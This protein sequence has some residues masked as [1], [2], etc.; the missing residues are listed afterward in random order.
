MESAPLKKRRIG[1]TNLYVTELG[2][3]GASIGNLFNPISNEEAYEV[4]STS[5]ELGI[6]YFDTAPEYGHGLSERRLGEALRN[7]PANE[8]ILSTKVGELLY[9]RH[10]QLP[11]PNKFIDKLP[12]HLKHDYS[13]DGVMRAFEDSL[14]RLGLTK[15]NI[16]F[17]H[18][19]DPIIHEENK[20]LLH[21]KTFIES[22][23][24]ALE[25]LRSAGIVDAIGLGVKKWEVC[26]EVMRY[27]NYDCFMLQGNYTLLEQSGAN[28]LDAC[29]KKQVSILLAGP[30]ASGILATG[31]VKGAYFHH[32]IA[33]DEILEQ[34]SAI[35]KI[36]DAFNIPMQAAAI[37]FPLK[38]PAVASVVVG[39]SS[40]KFM[41]QNKDFF[42]VPI[43][44]KLWEELQLAGI[45]KND[46]HR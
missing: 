23:Y 2:L 25:E 33:S 5:W 19:L 11:S 1:K 40:A 31:P 35:Q 30:Y 8:F 45:I 29:L 9:A 39:A 3:G 43:P 42:N 18:D 41:Q 36:C 12:F 32:Q 10:N 15:I 7:T 13:Y 14:Q 38:H 26:D 37:Q 46:D 4:I 21:F 20:F 27:G 44:E 34:V 28:F 17:V 24:R 16:L 22:G 6:R